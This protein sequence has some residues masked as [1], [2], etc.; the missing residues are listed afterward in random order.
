MKSCC[1]DK[2]SELIKLREQQGR[3]LKIVLVINAVMFIVEFTSGWYARSSALMADSLD[4]FGDALVYGFSLFVLHRSQK[5][6]ATAA[7]LKGIIISVFGLF[8]LVEVI[9]KI[10]SDVVPRAETMGLIGLVALLANLTCLFLLMKHK[11]DDINMRSTY[12]CSRNDIISN[13]GVIIASV[14]VGTTQSKWPDIAIGLL[15]AVLFLRSAWPILTES[16]S[17]LREAR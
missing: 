3:I 4:M 15:V 1:E 8:V 14:A 11:N 12:I 17:E 16:V 6:R 10:F 5:W 7:L 13:T 9:L 2:S